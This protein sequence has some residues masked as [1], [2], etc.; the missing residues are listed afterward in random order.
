MYCTGCG[1]NHFDF[2][3]IDLIVREMAIGTTFDLPFILP[4]TLFHQARFSSF[5]RNH[6]R[7]HEVRAISA[8]DSAFDLFLWRVGWLW[9]VL[10]AGGG[11]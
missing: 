4:D 1:T 2:D 10:F 11:N 3:L 6:L 7:V 8:W 9:L 5:H